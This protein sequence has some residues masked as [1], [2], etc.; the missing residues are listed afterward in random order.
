[1]LNTE[2]TVVSGTVCT[3]FT[4]AYVTTASILPLCLLYLCEFPMRCGFLLISDSQ[5]TNKKTDRVDELSRTSGRSFC[6]A[7]LHTLISVY[8]SPCTSLSC[9]IL[10]AATDRRDPSTSTPGARNPAAERLGIIS[11]VYTFA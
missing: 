6:H 5:Q 4:S 8:S 2:S 10:A 11:F 9:F 3:I 1:M 7:F